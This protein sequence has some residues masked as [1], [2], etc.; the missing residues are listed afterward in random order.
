MIENPKDGGE[1]KY[2]KDVRDGYAGSTRVQ[3]GIRH[4]AIGTGAKDVLWMTQLNITG[5]AHY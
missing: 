4:I 5:L 2:V 3:H 1:L